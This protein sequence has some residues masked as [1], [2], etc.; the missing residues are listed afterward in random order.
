[1]VDWVVGVAVVTVFVA[2]FLRGY[3]GFGASLICI[4]VL[5][6]FWP[7]DRV[8]PLVFLLEVGASLLM[9]RSVWGVV[10]W[11]S[12]SWLLVG[13][14]VATPLG[15]LVLSVVSPGIMSAAISVLIAAAAVLLLSGWKLPKMPGAAGTLG[16]GGLVGVLN[17]AAAIG[18]PPAVLFYYSAPISVAAVR[19]TLAVFFLV[20][21]AFG[22]GYAATQGFYD[23][24]LLWL[25]AA[26]TVA[27][28][29]GIWAGSRSFIFAD[30]AAVRRSALVALAGLAVI[31]LIRQAF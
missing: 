19:A 27:M 1:M 18:G 5:T 11:R 28:A 29:A 30:P 23:S 31:G 7:P 22:A 25:S 20:A 4:A 6:F 15:V 3:A 8:V 16:V 14:L 21:D 13:T 2:F 26:L 24:D 12:L 17:G 10:E 9:L